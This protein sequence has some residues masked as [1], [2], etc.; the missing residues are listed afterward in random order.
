MAAVLRSHAGDRTVSECSSRIARACTLILGSIPKARLCIAEGG[1]F[2]F[3]QVR[4]LS[5]APA[6]ASTLWMID[7]YPADIRAWINAKGGLEKMP[8]LNGYWYLICDVCKGNRREGSAFGRP[9]VARRERDRL[10]AARASG[11]AAGDVERTPQGIESS[12]VAASGPSP[13][14]TVTL[15]VGFVTVDL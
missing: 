10:S 8:Y 9:F 11:G 5:D 2:G 12:R 3:H 1:R 15:P 4:T 13:R 7:R 14:Q 6:P